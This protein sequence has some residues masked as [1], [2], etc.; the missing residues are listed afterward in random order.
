MFSAPLPRAHPPKRRDLSRTILR[1]RRRH[2]KAN[3]PRRRTLSAR[4]Q[5]AGP[6]LPQ[7]VRLSPQTRGRFLIP[8]PAAAGIPRPPLADTHRGYGGT[9]ARVTSAQVRPRRPSPSGQPFRLARSGRRLVRPLRASGGSA[10]GPSAA[11][12]R[13]PVGV[14][15][16]RPARGRVHSLAPAVAASIIART[17]ALIGPGN[18]G[19]ADTTAARSA[20]RAS[21][22]DNDT[23]MSERAEPS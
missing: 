18:V 14:P 2:V 16:G 6:A 11:S 20:G 13:P 15:L 3:P 22:P 7:R 23:A 8:H 1:P 12:P 9:P 5:A 19:Q 21:G 17:A 4:A 10:S